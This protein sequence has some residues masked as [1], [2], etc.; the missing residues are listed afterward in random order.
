MEN[1]V[2]YAPTKVIFG[3]GVEEQT[4]TVCQSFGGQRA[5]VVYGG[6]SVRQSGLLAKVTASLEEAGL[7]AATFGGAQPNPRVSLVR[8]GIEQ[9]REFGADFLI[10]LGGGS[11]IDTAK[12]IAIGLQ[13]PS[14]DIWQVWRGR[15]PFQ[16]ALPVGAVLTIPAAG[17]EMSDSAVLT[18]DETG[19]KRGIN[20]DEIRC[21]F[22]VM[23][24]LYCATV[25]V[26]ALRCGVVDIMMHTMDRYF[27][28]PTGNALSDAIAEG[29]LRV[30]IQHGPRAVAS[31]ADYHSMS[32]L[33]WSSSVSHNGLTGLGGA[34]D[35]APHNLSHGVSGLYDV[36]HGAALSAI[37]PAWA[38]YCYRENP[39][40]FAQFGE[41]VWGLPASGDVARDA[42]AAIARTETFFK[43]LEMPTNF[44]EL[45][46][47]PLDEAAIDDLA[48]HGSLNGTITLGAFKVLDRSAMREIYRLANH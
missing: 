32:E 14:D 18:Y 11:A 44:V 27:T 20:K 42:L 35:F 46:I 33:M 17:S 12:G 45:G 10:G 23:N 34:K 1:F 16:G 31:P 38:R 25:P 47:G 37:W 9:A 7:A 3:R 26:Y 39:A 29:L 41:Q 28:K 24:P 48:N 13:H 36:A 15:V 4:G 22:A 8:Q 19:E 21:R 5:F 30:V 40:R 43:E 2:Y 6:G